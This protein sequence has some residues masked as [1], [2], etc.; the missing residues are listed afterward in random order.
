MLL[1][2]REFDYGPLG[3][4]DEASFVKKPEE[5]QQNENQ[6]QDKWEDPDKFS[7]KAFF[8]FF[9]LLI[10]IVLIFNCLIR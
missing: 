6:Q 4:V 2:Q 5:G 7:W 3:P 9:V 10:I 1:F 8:A